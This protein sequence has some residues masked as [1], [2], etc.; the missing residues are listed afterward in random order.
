M[1]SQIQVLIDR[2]DAE[3]RQKTL[4]ISPRIA[5]VSG[6]DIE[7]DA[8]LV[9]R[10]QITYDGLRGDDLERAT[11]LKWLHNSGAGVNNLPLAEL[12]AR[13]VTLTN[14][15]GIHADCIA[16]HLFGM[17]LVVT[18]NLDLALDAQKQAKWARIGDQTISLRGQTL[19]VLGVGAIGTQIARV[20]RAFGLKIIGLRRGGESH[21]DIETMFSPESKREFFA[22]SDIVMN[23]LPLTEETRD[24][25][26][27]SEFDALPRGA[28]VANAGRGATIDTN[29]LVSALQS[30]KLRAA[31]LD[32]T[33]PEPLPSDHVLWSVSGVFITPH[34]AGTHPEYN[35][36]SDAIWLDNLRLYVAGEALHHAVNLRAGY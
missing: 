14:T 17:L 25:M 9:S 7:A 23:T 36:E 16:E 34:Y 12:E 33:E 19:G 20:G 26:G 8:D 6:A 32:V 22:Q 31:L 5:L 24:F 1:N 29:A 27:Q 13:G 15:S 3:L 21:P 11:S 28:I 4:E 30:G 10:I 18:R 35:A 2:D